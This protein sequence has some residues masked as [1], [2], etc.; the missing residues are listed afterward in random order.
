MRLGYLLQYIENTIIPLEKNT[1]EKMIKIHTDQ[2]DSN[3][4]YQFPF[5]QSYDPRVCLVRSKYP[6]GI[7]Q[8]L[9]ILPQLPG[10]FE[11]GN[12]YAFLMNIYVNF[13]QIE[14]SINDNLDEQGNLSLFDFLSSLCTSI[15][16]AL[17]GVNNLEPVIEEE[18]NTIRIIDGSYTSNKKPITDYT[19]ELYGYNPTN[20]SSNFVRNFSVKSTVS[21]EYASMISIGATAAGY[22]KGMEATMFSKWNTGI[23]DRFKEEYVPPD[24]STN[25]TGSANEAVINY[26]EN[27][28]FKNPTTLKPQQVDII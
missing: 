24:P 23:I 5:Q 21:K 7:N 25:P 1:S 15:N 12:D 14:S 2:W 6:V 11:E 8:S 3:R 13:S 22:T 28:L 18:T 27:V 19:L 4:M 26:I 10:W 16:K 9:E 17:G 20:N